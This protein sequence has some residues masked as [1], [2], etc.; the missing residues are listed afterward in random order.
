MLLRK[1]LINNRKRARFWW[2][3]SEQLCRFN[4]KVFSLGVLMFAP[5]GEKRACGTPNACSKPH[6]HRPIIWCS[7][8]SLHATPPSSIPT[9]D[10]GRREDNSD[11]SSPTSW[12]HQDERGGERG[13]GL[14][15]KWGIA[16]SLRYKEWRDE[17]SAIQTGRLFYTLTNTCP[18]VAGKFLWANKQSFTLL[19]IVDNNDQLGKLTSSSLSITP[20]FLTKKLW[21]I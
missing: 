1:R 15:W 9:L 19:K 21:M 14:V 16:T 4:S 10:Q 17:T 12:T 3:K 8:S 18:L 2:T 20:T 11:L 7:S 13:G 5:G 6:S